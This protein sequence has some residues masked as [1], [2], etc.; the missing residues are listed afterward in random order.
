MPLG[1]LIGGL[2]GRVNLALPFIVG[3]AGSLI[4]SLIFYRFFTR[5]PNPEDVHNGDAEPMVGPAGMV[6][7]D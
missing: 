1:A 6:L 5:L 7:E 3:G 4:V 2:L